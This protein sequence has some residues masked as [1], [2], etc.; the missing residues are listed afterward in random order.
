MATGKQ[1]TRLEDTPMMIKRPSISLR[2]DISQTSS[3]GAGRVLLRP[4]PVADEKKVQS[5][6]APINSDESKSARKL[7]DVEMLNKNTPPAGV[8]DRKIL[9]AMRG[10]DDH[11]VRASRCLS[12]VSPMAPCIVA[13]NSTRLLCRS[14][15][16]GIRACSPS[17][18]GAMS[19]PSLIKPAS[20]KLSHME[21]AMARV[22]VLAVMPMDK[23]TSA[24]TRRLSPPPGTASVE[25]RSARLP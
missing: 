4:G 25:E 21:V 10:S 12:H 23:P 22:E 11:D 7:E 24:A 1:A 17:F 20:S 2:P 19:K 13:K 8:C 16:A 3:S 9:P 18:S 6:M 5:A 14:V 15:S